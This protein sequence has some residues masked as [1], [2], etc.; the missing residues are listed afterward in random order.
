M[1]KITN[2]FNFT[3]NFYMKF[4]VIF[5]FGLLTLTAY[6]QEK[7][8]KAGEIEL[9]LRNTYSLFSEESTPGF[10]AGGQFRI[11]LAN[12]LNTEWFADLLKNN[13]ENLGSRT[14]SHI[15]W[16]VMFYPKWYNTRFT[17]YFLAGHCFD[18]TKVVR[19]ATSTEGLSKMERKSSAVQL[20]IGTSWFLSDR[21]NFSF[22]GQYMMHLGSEIH[23]NVETVGGVKQLNMVKEGHTGMEGHLLLTLSMNIKI[24]DAW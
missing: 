3:Q 5:V 22:S 2:I 15:G 20:G 6:S 9:G 10:G 23:T 8:K 4:V 1:L 14:D 21:V 7:E 13:I 18:Y 16:S 17:P 12:Q 11:R 24:F 19:F